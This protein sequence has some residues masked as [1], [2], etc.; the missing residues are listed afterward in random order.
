M[1]VLDFIV[2]PQLAARLS[3]AA[4]LHFLHALHRPSRHRS[5]VLRVYECAG[6]ALVLG[7]YHFA[8]R[9]TQGAVHLHRRVSGGRAMP[10]GAGYVGVSLA[11]PH[12]AALISDDP[13]SIAPYQVM[14]RYVR[15][16]L[17]ACKTVNL[18]VF[19]PGRD[20]ITVNRRVLGL[21]S[22]EV[23]PEGVLL[24]EAIIANQR[25]FSRLPQLLDVADPQG[26]VKADM[27]AADG[28]TCLARELRSSLTTDEVAEL[29]RRGY[30][31]QFDVRCEPHALSGLE[32]QA[33][34]AMATH[35]IDGNRWLL[36]RTERTE[37]ACRASVRS[38]LGVFD[39]HLALEQNR[40]IK[41]I[42]FSGDFIANS[43]GI[44]QLQQRLRL[45]PAEW[46]AIDACASEIFAHPENFILGVGRVHA[47]ADAICKAIPA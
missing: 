39:V 17:E 23:D 37:L 2:Q 44:E 41:D 13:L 25:D 26:V 45:C 40:F 29:L 20:V 33:I 15:G 6:D 21:V 22:F 46:R 47:I 11:L 8:P 38:Q 24:F 31:S 32:T 5:G 30:E 12:R 18:P 1:H 9:A 7:R 16:I 3:L 14:N 42:V 36:Q 28:T 34:E 43:P 10:F 35:E 19:Y 4:D 27:L